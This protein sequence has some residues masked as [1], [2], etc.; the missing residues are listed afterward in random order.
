[1]LTRLTKIYDFFRYDIHQGVHNLIR[2]FP[3]VWKFR[4]WDFCFALII[5]KKGLEILSKTIEC[6]NEVDEGRLPKV[7]AINRAVV[8][9]KNV[10]EENYIDLAEKDL[11]LEM[12]NL[13]LDFVPSEHGA[14]WFKLKD[15][16]T[17]EEQEID[18]Q[19]F[20]R[21]YE[22]EKEQW[23]ELKNL[24]FGDE[25]IPGSNMKGWWD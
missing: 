11:D 10:A 18:K 3:I 16:R 25:N 17:K 6:G 22:I 9:L 2:F 21:S 7:K 5:F 13:P 23:E 12:S 4:P 19:I 20:D 24:L 14:D 1:M 15:N 8:L